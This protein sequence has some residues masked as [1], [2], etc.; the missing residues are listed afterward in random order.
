MGWNPI[1]PLI[2]LGARKISD[3][4]YNKEERKVQSR[5]YFEIGKQIKSARKK[6]EYF[7]ASKAYQNK[8]ARNMRPV[9][10]KKARRDKFIDEI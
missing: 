7:D 9:D 1:K 8:Y 10:Q 4:R 3:S 5:T 6:G 2:K